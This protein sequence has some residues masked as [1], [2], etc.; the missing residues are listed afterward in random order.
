MSLLQ[1]YGWSDASPE[2]ALSERFVD[3]APSKRRRDDWVKSRDV[4]YDVVV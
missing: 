4:V 3:A 2:S 1:P